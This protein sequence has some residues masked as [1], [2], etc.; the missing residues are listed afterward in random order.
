MKKHFNSRLHHYVFILTLVVFSLIGV[1]FSSY[2]IEGNNNSGKSDININVG[3]YIDNNGIASMNLEKAEDGVKCFSF[4]K[5]G[6]VNDNV[7]DINNGYLYAYLKLD[8]NRIKEAYKN[9]SDTSAYTSL[10]FTSYLTFETSSSSNLF[11][12]ISE[13]FIST[14]DDS[15][16]GISAFYYSNL[17][18]NRLIYLNSDN[19]ISNGLLTS[20]FSCFN[21]GTFTNSTYFYLTLKFNFKIDYEKIDFETIIYPYLVNSKF[22]F[23]FGIGGY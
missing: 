13:N 20:N 9:P 10:F 19:S 12:L 16:C 17:N 22:S 15:T 7:I 23:N 1:G 21:E 11:T 14:K 2:L 8:V 6:F 18:T 5:D 3:D 4:C